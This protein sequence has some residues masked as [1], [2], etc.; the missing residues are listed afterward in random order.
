[1]NMAEFCLDCYNKLNDTRYSEKQVELEVD[2]CE[3][4]GE[5]KPVVVWIG[6]PTVWNKTKNRLYGWLKTC[7]KKYEE[8][9]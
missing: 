8:K 6:R 2:L 1:M 7:Q 5:W 3:G 9:N 4:C